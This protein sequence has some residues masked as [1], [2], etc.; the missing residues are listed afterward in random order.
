MKA[1][2]TNDML[3]LGSPKKHNFHDRL[4]KKTRTPYPFSIT[5]KDTKPSFLTKRFIKK[6]ITY[7]LHNIEGPHS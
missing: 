4:S 3:V 6:T 2:W 7:H 1:L 5:D